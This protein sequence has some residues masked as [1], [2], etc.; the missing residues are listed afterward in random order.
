[1]RTFL[2]MYLA[3]LLSGSLCPVEAQFSSDIPGVPRASVPFL[4]GNQGRTEFD[5]LYFAESSRAEDDWAAQAR[6][7]YGRSFRIASNFEFGFDFNLASGHYS[8]L[9]EDAIG[10]TPYEDTY[11]A[12][13]LLQGA[14]L[15]GL[16]FGLK[17]QPI[18]FVSPEG[19]GFSAAVGASYQP[20][21]SPGF[22][23]ERAGD[24]TWTG[25]PG[26]EKRETN[27]WPFPASVTAKQDQLIQFAVMA[28]YR[29]RRIVADAA[30]A[31]TSRSG[32]GDF[33]A[34]D[35]SGFS[36]KLGLMFRLTPGLALGGAVWGSGASPWQDQ[37]VLPWLVND[38]PSY[39]LVVGFGNRSEVGTDLI[40][41]SPSGS[42]SES[43]RLYIRVRT[44]Y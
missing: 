6:I 28:S 14:F 43:S 17:Y 34:D 30:L 42:L 44:S 24:S 27:P 10:A 29:S 36:P 33:P 23:L 21:L 20:S 35:F 25:Y 22:S 39:A 2:G 18:A 19:Y 31:S 11:Q 32:N 15:Y 7:G 16:R 12:T 8:K 3:L 38:S 9:D 5:F 4:G 40:V 41:M 1:M 13:S 37:I 26:S